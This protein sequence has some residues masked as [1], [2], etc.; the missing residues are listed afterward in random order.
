MLWICNLGQLEEELS[1]KHNLSVSG[2]FLKIPLSSF[3]SNNVLTM[4]NVLH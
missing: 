1:R 4:E 3:F 2:I